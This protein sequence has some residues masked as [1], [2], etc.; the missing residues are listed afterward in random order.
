MRCCFSGIIGRLT[1]QRTTLTP[2]EIFIGSPIEHASERATLSRTVEFLTAQGVPAVVLANVN[3]GGR[4]IDLVVGLDQHALV[5]ESKGFASAVHGDENGHWHVRL[6]SGRWKEIPNLYVQT[7][8]E[9]N[10][11]RDAMAAFARTAVPYPDAALVFVPA[12]PAGSMVPKG[13]FKVSVG[14]LDALPALIASTAHRGW[15]LDQWRAFAAHHRL[16]AVPSLDAALSPGL[17]DA[18]RLLDAY[19]G[20]FERTYG[21]LASA[22]V[23][24][25]CVHDG[26]TLAS[27]IV[28]E[29]GIAGGNLLLMGASG[30]G[31][32]LLSYMAALIA[33]GRGDVPIVIPAKDFEGNLRDV[34]NREATLLDARS[35]VALIRAAGLLDRPLLLVVDGY[36]ECTPSERQRLTRSIAAAIKRYD[37]T[38]VISSRIE[39]ERKDLLPV[40]TYAVQAPDI[41]TKQAIARQAAGN[42]SVEAFSELLDTVGSGLEARMVG[43]LGRNLPAGTTKYGL[44][45]AYVRERLGPAASDG[46]R[47]LSRIAGMM[48]DRI[49]FGLSVRDLDRLSDR[50]G[51]SGAL[52]QTLQAVNLLDKRGDRLSFSHEMFLNVFGA[53]AILRRAGDDPDA[54]VSALRLSRHLEM[55]PFVLGAIDDDRLRRQVLSKLSDVWIVSACL[56]GQFGGD[57]RLWANRRCDDVLARVGQEI[58]TVRFD[59]S[60]DVAWNVLSKPETLQ[61]WTDQDRAVLGA[62]ARELVAGLR[63]D[64]VLDLVGKMDERLA[65][66]Y[67]RLFDEAKKQKINLRSGLYAM[68]YT[69]F[70]GREIG[71][72][73]ICNPIHSGHLY[74][75]PNIAAEA[76]LR[77]RLRSETLSPGQVGLLI[78]LDRYSQRDADSIGPLLP[79]IL[80]RIWA[81]AAHQLRSALMQA[82]GMS[83]RSLND[84]ERQALIDVIQD[85]MPANNG[86]DSTGMIDAL[87]FLGALDDDQAEHIASVKAE[88]EAVLANRDD[89]LMFDAAA[90]LWSAQFDHPYDGAYWEAWSDLPSDDRKTLLAMAAQNVDRHSMFTPPLLAD[91][92]SYG[93]PV[94]GPI[95]AQWTALPPKKEVMM[96]DTIRTFEMAHAAL[97]RLHHP[98]PDRSAEVLSPAD[99]ALLAC[100]EIIYWLNRDDLT[101]TERRLNCAAPLAVLSRHAD[102]V[103]A[104]VLREFSGS[105]HT[106]S[107]SAA[108]LPGSE[109]VATSITQHFPDEIT[110]I[111]RAALEQ[112]ARQTGYFE[113]FRV[114]DVIEKAL[115]SLGH[116]GYANDI[117]LLRAWSLHPKH[118]HA[119]VRAIKALEDAPRRQAGSDS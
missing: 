77:E 18:E 70:G 40:D 5:I 114:D 23:S 92:A 51:V 115:A 47:A 27:E 112:P 109:P 22:M 85:L 103:A 57:A 12:I 87:K 50:E 66:E 10:A 63:L 38:V 86:F 7:L 29:R 111:Y 69:G 26:E 105:D 104:A 3:F 95:V 43:Q 61:E 80:K 48:T 37:A 45:D 118:G 49:S 44:F 65:E 13:D 59:L 8:A 101:Q 9:K 17:L 106:F 81:K 108:R 64:Q 68:S 82:A 11:L 88:M 54:V 83:A 32:S 39:L 1:T 110:S 46:I 20:A 62:V 93:D 58:E 97:A 71:L 6:A 76:N 91:L 28:A 25:S 2:F 113:F 102:G 36:N 79:A 98:L 90:G 67:S 78:E 100:G 35:A 74:S 33:L 72:A 30:C 60:K 99:H 24:V 94:T 53:E 107:E 15:S 56:A 34:A 73:C 31:K 75:G 117:Q 119:A 14:G 19:G 4:Q 89:P 116:A 21:P 42:G 41:R 84:D 96:Q 55:K 52:L 16:I